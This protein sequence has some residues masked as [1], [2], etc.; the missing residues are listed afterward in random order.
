MSQPSREKLDRAG[1][2]RCKYLVG[3]LGILALRGTHVWKSKAQLAKDV[4]DDRR[5]GRSE[6]PE[7]T[8]YDTADEQPR[9]YRARTV[10]PPSFVAVLPPHCLGDDGHVQGSG[11]IHLVRKDLM[12]EQELIHIPHPPV[13]R[14]PLD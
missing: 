5:Q 3:S 13:Q 6:D 12:F 14:R 1:P 11:Q 4:H 10:S 7:R 9:Q 2:P 8:G